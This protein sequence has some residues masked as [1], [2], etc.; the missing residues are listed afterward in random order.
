MTDIIYARFS[1]IGTR[2]KYRVLTSDRTSVLLDTVRLFSIG[3]ADV[4]Y[5]Q[6]VTPDSV[7]IFYLK[8]MIDELTGVV[9]IRPIVPID[10]IA[11]FSNS[12]IYHVNA[13]MALFWSIEYKHKMI[14]IVHDNNN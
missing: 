10:E 7:Y 8:I 11:V 5:L 3:I 2:N 9:P 12:G 1:S 13:N 6:I 14:S 4:T